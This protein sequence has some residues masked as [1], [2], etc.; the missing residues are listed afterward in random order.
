MCRG[1]LGASTVRGCTSVGVATIRRGNFQSAQRGGRRL[2][3]C[4]PCFVFSRLLGLSTATVAPLGVSLGGQ[5]LVY[6]AW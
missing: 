2:I 5:K 3:G 1:T 6:R 4:G